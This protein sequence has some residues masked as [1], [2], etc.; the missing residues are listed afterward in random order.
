MTSFFDV[1]FSSYIKADGDITNNSIPKIS[2][3]TSGGV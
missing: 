2:W 1:D 3:I